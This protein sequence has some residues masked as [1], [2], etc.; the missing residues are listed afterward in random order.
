V[1][2]YPAIAA[3]TNAVIRLL[4][5]A[6]ATADWRDG[7]S[8]LSV[9]FEPAGTDILQKPP[10]D[11]PKVT[12]YLYRINLSSVRRHIGPRVG[13]DGRRY[14]PSLA[15]DLYYLLTAWAADPLLQQQLLGWSITVLDET[16]VL[17]P[18]LLNAY[19][20][21]DEIFRSDETVEFVWNPL[22][23]ADLSEIWEVAKTSQQPS[24][25]FVARMV[26]LDSA[27][28]MDEYPLVQT[29]ELDFAEAGT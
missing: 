3:T 25:S 8:P 21:G 23:L 12:L 20:G 11:G 6:A 13:P 9:G 28:L 19:R 24:A 17:P 7:G 16:P 2:A 22:P 1:A 29:R 18:S 26:Q 14:H 5:T 15:V 4:E 27:V 10:T